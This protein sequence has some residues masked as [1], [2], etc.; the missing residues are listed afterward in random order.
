MNQEDYSRGE[1]AKPASLEIAI[2]SLKPDPVA[3]AMLR[4]R[5]IQYGCI[6]R[7]SNHWLSYYDINL[8]NFN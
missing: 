2:D 1:Q 6:G 7:T 8:K 3:M 5:K 4:A